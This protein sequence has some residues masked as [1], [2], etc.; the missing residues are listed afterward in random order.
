MDPT[1][2]TVFVRY[3]MHFTTHT[4]CNLKYTAPART[5]P[6]SIRTATTYVCAKQPLLYVCGNSPARTACARARTAAT[7]PRTYCNPPQRTAK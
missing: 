6:A 4:Y 2:R 5:V 3:V 7:W 1:P